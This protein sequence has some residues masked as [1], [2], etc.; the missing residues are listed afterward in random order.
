L[1]AAPELSAVFAGASRIVARVTGGESLASHPAAFGTDGPMRGAMMDMVFGTLRRYGRGDALVNLLAHRGTPDP[2][3]RALLLCALYAIESAAYADHVAVDQ[4]VK[5]CMPLDTPGAKGFVNALLR[6]FLRERTALDLQVSANRVAQKMH[7]GWWIEALRNAYPKDWEAVLD[8]GNRH[9]PM[10][11]RVN[12]RRTTVEA[13]IERLGGEG[14][15]AR[16]TGE[17]AL[18]LDRPVR[19]DRLPGFTEG[20]ISVQDPGAQRAAGYLDLHDGQRVLDACAA[21][22]GKTCHILETSAVEMLALDADPD[23]CDRVRQNLARLGLSAQVVAA[24][25]ASPEDWWDGRPFDRILADVP[26]T[27]SGIVRRHPDIKWLRRQ[28]DPARFAAGQAKILDAL[29]RVLA[30]DGKLLYVTCSVFPEENAK[31][32][33]AFCAR[34]PGA[35]SLGLPGNAPAQ[36]LPDDD[37]DGFF[38]ALLQK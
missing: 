18:A 15:Q 13:C 11:L 22:G 17:H 29:W 24:D 23:R 19:V 1:G 5:A 28:G 21:P 37:H 2:Q 16:Q 14:I 4:A 30:P 35:R 34:H 32:V 12:P 9:P 7:P 6:R 8:A 20:E 36:L 27:A 33:D 3:V 26:C 25:C 10:G 38:F 31:V